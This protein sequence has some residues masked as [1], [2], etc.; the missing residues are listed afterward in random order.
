M[1]NLIFEKKNGIAYVTLNRPESLNC[2]NFEMLSEL[3]VLTEELRH[4]REIRV[5][6]FTGAG[7]KSFSSGA[8]LKERLTLGED[9]VRRNVLKI[10]TVFHEISKLPQVTIAAVNGYAFGGGF[11]L[12]LACD[13]RLAAGHAKM[14]LTETSWAIIPGAGGTQ[15][16][17][18]LIGE[19]R[20]KE[21][22]LTA[23][24]MDAEQAYQYG[25]LTRTVPGPELMKECEHLAQEI[26]RNGPV[27]VEQAKYAIRAGMETDLES[28]LNIEAEAYEQTIPTYD[29]R[30]ALLAFSEKRAPEFMG[31]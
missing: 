25:I 28:G 13:F 3:G 5:V 6:I 26:L 31:K 18:R 23:R 16:L 8:D 15:R 9:D 20:A 21:L 22:I 7:D 19:A 14:G 29:R 1:K 10:R 30:E 11:E 27:A 4:D 2:F 24:K 12:M 17:P